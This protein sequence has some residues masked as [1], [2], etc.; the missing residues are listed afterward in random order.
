M[1]GMIIRNDDISSNTKFDGLM[2]IY[3]SILSLYPNCELW[4]CV[5]QF[6]KSTELGS[7]YPG[8]P[9]KDKP[10]DYFLD[11]DE[12]TGSPYAELS[13]VVS[14]GLWHMDHTK[15]D[16]QLKKASIVSSCRL[17][18]TDIFVPPF[19]RFDDEMDS[20]CQYFGIQLVKSDYEGWRSFEHNKFDPTHELW[21]FH[22]WRWDSKT[23]KDYLLV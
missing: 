19:N 3:Q 11:V 17:L 14:H 13:K 10:F 9:L 6:S 15:I 16:S 7:V 2:E 23:L 12:Y 21:Y 4:S 1:D 20:I 8:L 22:S 18:K 5:T